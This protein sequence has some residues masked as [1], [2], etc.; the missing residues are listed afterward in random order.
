MAG[1]RRSAPRRRHQR[2]RR[3]R[4]AGLAARR[5]QHD[6]I[7]WGDRLAA[8]RGAEHDV[9]DGTQL[10]EHIRDVQLHGL[11]RADRATELLAVADLIKCSTSLQN[12]STDDFNIRWVRPELHC[13]Y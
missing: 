5:H 9:L 11:E 6:G 2:L 7:A 4:H 13:G 10:Q 12:I 3:A 1:S 8:G